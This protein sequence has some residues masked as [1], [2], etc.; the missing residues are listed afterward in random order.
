MRY[1]SSCI[2]L[3]NRLAAEGSGG[4]QCRAIAQSESY[5]VC[6]CPVVATSSPIAGTRRLQSSNYTMQGAHSIAVST[7]LVSI[8]SG[9]KSTII[10]AKDLNSD[11]FGK[12]VTV[13]VTMLVLAVLIVFFIGISQH[14]D[15]ED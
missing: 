10:S 9:M 13:F 4:A 11:V 1:N 12:D 3:Y 14:L 8:A 6:K 2:L 7:L 15:Y 5:T